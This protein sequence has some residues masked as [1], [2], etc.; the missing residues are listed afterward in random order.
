MITC[1]KK[2]MAY[3]NF[4]INPNKIGI[5][6]KIEPIKARPDAFRPLI[7]MPAYLND[8]LFGFEIL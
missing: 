7:C 5:K 4:G 2:I 6:V 8:D 1:A 3:I